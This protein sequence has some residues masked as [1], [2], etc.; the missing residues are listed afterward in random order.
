MIILYTLLGILAAI[1]FL[2]L[3][4]I[5]LPLSYQISLH[6]NGCQLGIRAQALGLVSFSYETSNQQPTL[7]IARKTISLQPKTRQDKSARNNRKKAA[8]T[9]NRSFKSWINL[10]LIEQAWL[11]VKEA[12]THIM[13]KSIIIQGK[14]GL[15]DPC[16]TGL[17]FLVLQ[18]IEKVPN[19]KVDLQPVWDSQELYIEFQAKGRIIITVLL[20][21]AA[22]F[23]FSAP[24]RELRRKKTSR[25]RLS[26]QPTA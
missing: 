9:K 1:I 5:V 23:F 26:L 18:L 12:V 25:S 17:L 4:L 24:M 22:K 19:S 13:P 2:F 7:L 21:Y 8:P 10:P 14:I 11:L 20:F 16:D 6:L 3:I 15:D